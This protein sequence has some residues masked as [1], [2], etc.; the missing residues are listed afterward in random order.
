MN[1]L[2]NLLHLDLIKLESSFLQNYFEKNILLDIIVRLSLENIKEILKYIDLSYIDKNGL[3]L[4][5]YFFINKEKDTIDIILYLLNIGYKLDN[6]KGKFNNES[7]YYYKI[8]NNYSFHIPFY[9]EIN[10]NFS[11]LFK[12]NYKEY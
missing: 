3:T 12:H 8:N 1:I 10:K 6:K 7:N 5:N 2:S 11:E 4:L 9:K